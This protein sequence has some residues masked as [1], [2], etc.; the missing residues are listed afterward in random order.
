[1]VWLDDES[2]EDNTILDSTTLRQHT[3]IY[4]VCGPYD[5][6][7]YGWSPSMGD[8][9]LPT[10]GKRCIWNP[11]L[12]QIKRLP[13]LI[14]K[15]PD[16]VPSNI[17]YYGENCGFGFD[18]IGVDYKVVVIVGYRDTTDKYYHRESYERYPL[19]ALVYSLRS[20]SWR[21]I[22]DLSRH[23]YIGESS[24]YTFV[25]TSYYWL[26][27]TEDNSFMY[28][29][30][31]IVNLATEAI[32]EIGLPEMRIKGPMTYE[33]YSECLM[34]YNN[35]IALT[36]IYKDE[37]NFDIWMLKGRSW[38]KDL[39]IKLDYKIENLL[40][41][42]CSHKNMILF[43]GLGKL[44]LYY[45][46]S[47]ESCVIPNINHDGSYCKIVSAYMESLVSLNDQEF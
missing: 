15:R 27:S 4:D 31:I 37:H 23:Y 12:K 28:N 39:S 29:V 32:E 21:Y 14:M 18:P 22:G 24:S 26:A 13:P 8:D 25:D 20:N 35:S 43:G 7:Y 34:K 5:G 16:V 47:N 40:G 41:Y 3:S 17:T 46:D 45:I 6:L 33:S 19:S 1:M 11:A 2:D 44:I 30:I 9:W 38:S 36:V 42:Y 10:T